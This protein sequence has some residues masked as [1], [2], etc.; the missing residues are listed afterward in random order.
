MMSGGHMGYFG[1]GGF[2]GYNGMQQGFNSFDMMAGG[3]VMTVLVFGLIA[4]ALYL[5]FRNKN[6]QTSVSTLNTG[7]ATVI[8]AEEIA[9][10]RYARGEI[11]HEE[12][13]SILKTIKL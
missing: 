1:N 10:L 13:Q 2:N 5:I 7:N 8:E 11:T 4:L 12:F 6:Q 9:K 3:S